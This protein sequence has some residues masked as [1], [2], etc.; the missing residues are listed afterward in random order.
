[1]SR[2]IAVVGAGLAGVTTAYELAALGFQVQVFERGGSV[3]EQASFA[4][5]ALLSP[6]LPGLAD[7]SAPAPLGFR[8]RRWRA[9]RKGGDD[10]VSQLAALSRL[11]LARTTELRHELGLDDE[12]SD[13]LLIALADAKRT[14]AAEALLEGWQAL[15]LQVELIEAGE[16]RLREPGLNADAP[17]SAA[18][19][20]AHG[21]A[22]NARLFAQQLRLQAQRLG[23]GFRFHTT[24][25]AIAADGAGL[26]LRHEYTPPAEAPTRSA[27]REAGDTLPQPLGPQDERFDAAVLCNGLD[28]PTL[29]GERLPLSAQHEASVTAPLRLVEGY[30]DLGPKAGWVDPSRDLSVAR[31]GQRVRV[32]GGLTV[33]D[34]RARVNP[35]YEALHRGLQH[36]FPGS[37][38]HQQVQQGQARRAMSADGLPLLGASGRPGL[39]LNLSLGG[40]GWGLTCGSAQVLA[41]LIAGQAPAVDIAA[42]GPQR[43]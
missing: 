18:L 5:S 12:A 8:L 32:S 11:S 29:L 21:G 10:A 7:A 2:S 19:A 37:V 28:A 23:A 36:W 25:R 42:L 4:S 22:G 41:Q 24:V 1:M 26:M 38:L 3:A 17:L 43:L 15:G 34:A 40:Q 9:G 6:F 14:A 16:A 39:W 13:G 31:A 30:P 33:T 20:L 35:D 27:E